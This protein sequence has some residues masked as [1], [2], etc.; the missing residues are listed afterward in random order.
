MKT[1]FKLSLWALGALLVGGAL[2][3]CTN[4]GYEPTPNQGANSSILVKAPK[5]TAYS[6]GHE[7]NAYGTRGNAGDGDLN[8]QTWRQFDCDALENITDA[9]RYAVLE[10]IKKKVTG[11]KISE[12]VVFPWENYFLQDVINFEDW[13]YENAGRNGMSDVSVSNLE[14]FALGGKCD[15]QYYPGYDFENYANITNSKKMNQ[16]F[17]KVLANGQQQRIEKTTLMTDMTLGTY[18][19]MQGRQFRV[20]QNCH[21]E[22]HYYDYIT[23]EVDGNWY[24][25]FD[26]GCGDAEHDKD[27][28]PGRGATYNDWDYNDWIIKVTPAYPKGITPPDPWTGI[29]PEDPEDPED[30][31]NNVTEITNHVEVNLSV[32]DELETGDYIS[33]HLSIHVRTATDVDV[34]IPVPKMYYCDK[35]DMEIVE[36]HED[37]Y[38]EYGKEENHEMS[39]NVGGQTVTLKVTYEENGIRVTTSGINQAVIDYCRK[40]YNDGITFEVWSYFNED[41][42]RELLKPYFDKSTVSFTEPE[43]VDFYV[44][45]FNELG[46]DENGLGNKNEWDCTVDIREDQRGLFNEP[47][48]GYHYNY[49]RFNE[50]YKKKSLGD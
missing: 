8:N 7:L 32:N 37:G 4:E 49:S 17:L 20:Y 45:A 46:K 19:E 10:A 25:C 29:D 12:E 27:G 1:N 47:E 33:S 26:F 3:S 18:E 50:I 6:G 22:G 39:Y 43:N 30:P 13:N 35:D 5:F 21:I 40:E 16:Y 24:I 14:A 9:E 28:N 11:S 44:N 15:Q 42:T 2:T 36:K 48:T 31:D 34:F 23:V 41:A 38:F